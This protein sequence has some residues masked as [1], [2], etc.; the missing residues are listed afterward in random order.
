[1]KTHS[2][3]LSVY[4]CSVIVLV[5]I[6]L[7][8]SPAEAQ[9][10]VTS[11]AFNALFTPGQSRLYY[12]ADSTVLKV[13]IGKK[14]GPNVYDFS[15]VKLTPAGTSNNYAVST[16]PVIAARYPGNAVT[17]GDSRETIEKNPV[18]LLSGDTMYTLGQ[19][20]VYP[21]YRFEHYRP[22]EVLPTPATYLN[23]Y[24]R[25]GMIYDTTYNFTGGVV[26]AYQTAYKDSVIVDGYG[27]VKILGRQFECLRVNMKHVTFNDKEFMFFT[28]EGLFIDV[29]ASSTEP[30]TGSVRLDDVTIMLAPSLVGVNEQEAVPQG[31]TLGQ[32]YP[33]PFNPST[34]IPYGLPARAA[35]SLKIFNMLGQCV[36]T[37]VEGQKEAGQYQVQWTANVSSGIYYY[38]MQA[39]QFIETKK[40]VLLK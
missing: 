18:F 8:L 10:T 34:A 16:I 2:N 26:N 33:N 21:Q 22:Y 11:S 15:G 27:T 39:G 32:N 19:V 24:V 38:R 30:D 20:S 25:S 1:M 35:V 13:N 12:H 37:L 23:A 40:L 14:G 4:S 36:A 7:A 17:F 5:G 29:M 6:V 3:R 28:R 9:I 31:F